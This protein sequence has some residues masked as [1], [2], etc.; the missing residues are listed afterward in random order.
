MGTYQNLSPPLTAQLCQVQGHPPQ[1][2]GDLQPH[3]QGTDGTSSGE[4]CEAAADA[5]F[6]KGIPNKATGAT[7]ESP[8]LCVDIWQ[9]LKLQRKVGGSVCG[10]N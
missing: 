8:M 3:Q 7:P 1:Q 4:E 2:Q 9:Q 6:N 5:Q 10:L